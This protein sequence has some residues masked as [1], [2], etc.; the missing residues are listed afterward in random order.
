M[1]L[2]QIPAPAA[3]MEVTEA[4]ATAVSEAAKLPVEDQNYI[5]FRIMEEIAAEKKWTDSFSR[6]PE[7]LDD[8]AAQ[9]RQEIAE[10]KIYSL[11]TIL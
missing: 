3:H 8:L 4:L 6:S 7:I 9:A 10:G 2:L 11:E 1:Q 5:A